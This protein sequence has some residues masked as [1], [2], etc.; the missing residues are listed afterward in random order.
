MIP[1]K[2]TVPLLAVSLV[3]SLASATALA[4][5]VVV[6]TKSY[7]RRVD[8]TDPKQFDP[9]VATCQKAMAAMV[10]CVTLGGEDPKSGDEASKNFRVW[11]REAVE[12]TCAGNKLSSW[13][14]TPVQ[15]AFGAEAFLPT[16]GDVARNLSASPGSQ[17]STPIDKVTFSY[18]VRGEPNPIA[19]KALQQAKPRSC[20]FIWHEVSATLT[21]QAG[22]PKLDATVKGSSFPS[23][24]WWVQGEKS[25]DVAQGP[26]NNLWNCDPADPS[27]VK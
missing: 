1:S 14:L 19:S 3:S 12:V 4:E 24:R 13:K 27:Y 16:T 9:G 25:G 23:H 18:K 7:I 5:I 26:F 6:D 10:D 21:C 17:G 11:S 15:T 22:K 20:T 8:L 2:R